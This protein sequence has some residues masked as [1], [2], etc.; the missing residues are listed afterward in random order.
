MSEPRFPVSLSLRLDWSEMD[1]F[2][3]INNVSYF[4][5]I[6]ASRVNYWEVCGFQESFAATN[7]GPMLLSTGCRFKQ[8]LFYPGNIVVQA[9]VT[10]IKNTSFGI[11]HQVLNNKG[12]ICAE[13]EDVIVVFDFNNNT[14]VPVTDELRNSIQQLEGTVF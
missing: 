10:F 13:A 7:V 3:H 8:P 1:M 5:Y 2:G 4:K 12:E 14:K 11:R 9:S 6:Q